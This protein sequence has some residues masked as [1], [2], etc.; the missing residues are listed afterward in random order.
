M[1]LASRHNKTGKKYRSNSE[2]TIIFQVEH[3]E[4]TH[5]TISDDVS[6]NGKKQI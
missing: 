2:S 3:D 6:T 5:D 1:P 4:S